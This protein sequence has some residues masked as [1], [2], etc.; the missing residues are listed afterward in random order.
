MNIGPMKPEEIAEVAALLRACF[1]W[2]SDREGFNEVQRAY[3]TGERSSEQ[4]V[5]EE[6]AGRPHLVARR[7]GVILGMA[8]V[9]GNELARLYVHPRYHRQGVGRALFQAAENLI[10]QAGHRDMIVGALVESAAKFYQS[11]GM[12]VTSS[13]EYQPTIFPDRKVTLLSKVLR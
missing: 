3:L 8:A 4:T 12:Y 6:A 7:S 13:V 2:L 11:M 10:W 5:R 1:H 9:S